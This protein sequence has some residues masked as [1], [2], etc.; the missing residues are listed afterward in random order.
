MSVRRYRASYSNGVNLASS[1]E[2]NNILTHI[3]THSGELKYF[4]ERAKRCLYIY[5]RDA[6]IYIL[7]YLIMV[8]RSGGNPGFSCKPMFVF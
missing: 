8:R 5:L 7:T 3:A 6:Y 4:G 2:A 1:E